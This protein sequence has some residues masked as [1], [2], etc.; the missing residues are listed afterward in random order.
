MAAALHRAASP[1]PP[2][3]R[4]Y[5]RPYRRPIRTVHPFHCPHTRLGLVATIPAPVPTLI[6]LLI[7][8]RMPRVCTPQ[9]S[10]RIANAVVCCTTPRGM[11]QPL[12]PR[13]VRRDDTT[14]TPPATIT[15]TWT[16]STM[17]S[18]ITCSQ[19]LAR[20]LTAIAT[21]PPSPHFILPLSTNPHRSPQAPVEVPA[22]EP[23]SISA[24]APPPTSFIVPAYLFIRS[25][26]VGFLLHLSCS[27]HLSTM[28]DPCRHIRL[29]RLTSTSVLLASRTLGLAASHL[30]TASRPHGTRLRPAL[31]PFSAC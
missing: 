11:D 9:T 17:P 8:R 31:G 24:P 19:P 7:Q 23:V 3:S 1:S 13:P 21:P 22:P 27:C 14:T 15:S 29:R 20:I 10:L 4:T 5:M 12:Q 16:I 26:T 18:L 6:R 2:A 25:R 28:Y 30:S